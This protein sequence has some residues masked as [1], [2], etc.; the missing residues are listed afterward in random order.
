MKP[1][2]SVRPQPAALAF[3]DDE[4]TA[5]PRLHRRL[6]RGEV[7]GR[8]PS[9]AS[10]G[11]AK[12]DPVV[13][14]QG[15]FGLTKGFLDSLINA[16]E[17]ADFAVLVATQDDALANQERMAPR[18]NVM[19]ELGLFIG[20]L[21][22]DRALL[23]ADHSANGIKLPTDMNGIT[24]A[25]YFLDGSR[26]LKAALTRAALDITEHIVEVGPRKRMPVR[27]GTIPTPPRQPIAAPARP[28]PVTH[29]LADHVERLHWELQSVAR[30]A[31]AQGWKVKQSETTL[32]LVDPHRKRFAFS[33]TGHP[34][35]HVP[36]SATSRP[37]YAP[38]GCE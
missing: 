19:L 30:S 20:A 22:R 15:T 29:S 4:R 33:I 27:S 10:A 3:W 1:S 36:N 35:R 24:H 17:A 26:N 9:G 37:S 6:L 18:D 34:R 5:P 38:T 23:V 21:G 11:Y 8:Y 14:D 12:C 7:R 13:W 32:R 31:Q 2:D 25:P 28:N 16:A